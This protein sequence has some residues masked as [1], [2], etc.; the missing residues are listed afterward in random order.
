MNPL[1]WIRVGVRTTFFNYLALAIIKYLY[2]L[3]NITDSKLSVITWIACF[4][5]CIVDE[6]IKEGELNGRE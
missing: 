4:I 6:I 5:Y 3:K 2:D 1:R